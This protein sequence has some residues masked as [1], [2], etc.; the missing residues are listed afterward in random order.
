MTFRYFAYLINM[1][2][3]NVFVNWFNC[4]LRSWFWSDWI[5][6]TELREPTT[7]A[8]PYSADKKS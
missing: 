2:R 5:I 6:A 8:I 3:T 7:E 4:I 1:K